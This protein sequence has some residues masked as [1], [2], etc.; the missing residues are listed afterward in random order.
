MFSSVFPCLFK[1]IKQKYKTKA[2]PSH[3]TSHK[4]FHFSLSRSLSLQ[5]DKKLLCLV[6]I[7]MK[8]DEW[9]F[10]PF[11]TLNPNTNVMNWS[12]EQKLV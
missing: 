5:V 4:S 6:I 12:I 9:V 1:I 2:T 11:L 7:K 10:D 8:S 3:V